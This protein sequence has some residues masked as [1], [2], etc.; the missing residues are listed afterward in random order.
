MS[1]NLHDAQQPNAFRLTI[2]NG[3]GNV[4]L[5]KEVIV[6]PFSTET[7]TFELGDLPTSGAIGYK[8]IAEGL[9]GLR[10]RDETE[11][12]VIRKT[13]T[14]LVQTDKA[15]Y[16]PGD[17]IRFRI[18][19][20]DPNTKPMQLNGG[21]QLDMLDGNANRVMQWSNATVHRGVH[22]GEMQLSDYPVLGKWTL[23]VQILGEIRKKTIEVAEY[24]LPKFEVSI[25]TEK[26]VVYTH[27]KIL[28]NIRAK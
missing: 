26:D 19:V 9:T 4:R 24:V 8:L 13:F 16:K 20:L 11:L 23:H 21:L 15:L 14:V 28:A 25:E 6:K 27:N 3:A 17:I 18:L 7:V 10:F 2:D 12:L 1:V 5:S 22:S